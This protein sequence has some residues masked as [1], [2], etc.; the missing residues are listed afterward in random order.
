[1]IVDPV[2]YSP[3]KIDRVFIDVSMVDPVTGRAV[4]EAIL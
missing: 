4:P 2:G 3:E 1:M